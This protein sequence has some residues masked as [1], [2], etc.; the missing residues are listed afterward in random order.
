MN[1]YVIPAILGAVVLIAA[2]FAFAPVQKATTVHTNLNTVLG[3]LI[4][5]LYDHEDDDDGG[6]NPA[7]NDCN[8]D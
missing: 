3:E 1:K 8:L 5:D 7:T 4:C 6:F 2:A